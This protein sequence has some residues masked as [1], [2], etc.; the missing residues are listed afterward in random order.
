M[1]PRKHYGEA[2]RSWKDARKHVEA[3]FVGDRFAVHAG[4]AV[5]QGNH[6]PRD[7]GI[8]RIVDG[9]SNS[10]AA[11]LRPGRQYGQQKSGQEADKS[12]QVNHRTTLLYARAY[13]RLTGKS[14]LK[15]ILSSRGIWR[16][17]GRLAAIRG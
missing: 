3:G 16:G 1:H 11:G 7:H 6:G 5:G 8:R 13:R 2:I 14:I 4:R 10:G 9:S 17:H 12:S 15:V